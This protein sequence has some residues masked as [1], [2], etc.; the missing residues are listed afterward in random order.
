MTATLKICLDWAAL[1]TCAASPGYGGRGDTA[2]E[3]ARN[4]SY[5]GSTA[6]GA[7][8]GAT[9]S[10]SALAGQNTGS[11]GN[12]GYT[13]NQSGSGITGNQG[14]SGITGSRGTGTGTGITSGSGTTS[15]SRGAGTG[16]TE[17]FAG[18]NITHRS[19]V[20]VSCSQPS[21]ARSSQFWSSFCLLQCCLNWCFC[22][23]HPTRRNAQYSSRFY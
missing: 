11:S 5:E 10:T 2:S 18:L 3:E 13:G 14:T 21:T 20:R 23:N 1:D 6:S 8:S 7:R 19:G 15:G 12:Q 16:I 9:G 4:M 17:G 22:G